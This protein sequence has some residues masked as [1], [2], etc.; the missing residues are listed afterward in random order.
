MSDREVRLDLL[1]KMRGLKIKKVVKTTPVSNSPKKIDEEA[2]ESLF[3]DVIKME[4]TKK[5]KKEDGE[6]TT[7]LSKPRTRKKVVKQNNGSDNKPD[8]PKDGEGDSV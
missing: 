6:T 1:A 3:K 8:A 2:N 7:R 4:V 5:E